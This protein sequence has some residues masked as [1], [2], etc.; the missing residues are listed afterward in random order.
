MP[1]RFRKSLKIAPGVRLNLSKG[2]ISTSLGGR[3]HSINVGKGGV[4]STVGIPGTGLSYTAKPSGG[5]T[6][7]KSGCGL[8]AGALVL[9]LIVLACGSTGTAVPAPVGIDTVIAATAHALAGPPTSAP[10][11]AQ[12]P[13]ATEVPPP[14]PAAA[15]PPLAQVGQTIEEQ[16]YR[17]TVTN[18]ESAASYGIYDADAGKQLLAVEVLVESGTSSGVDVNPFYFSVQDLDGYEYTI[19]IFGKDPSL[20]SQNDLPAGEKMRGW[21]TFE[22][23]TT[24]TGLC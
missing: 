22:V 10:P 15:P 20:Q 19:S 6:R 17:F 3:G 4:K 9:G 13:A 16:G 23:P 1:F 11:P 2:G 7:N 21:V 8:L 24:H 5:Q 18:V 14:A 12:A